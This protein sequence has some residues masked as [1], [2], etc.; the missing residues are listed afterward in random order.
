MIPPLTPHGDGSEIAI[1]AI[2][3]KVERARNFDTVAGPGQNVRNKDRRGND[4]IKVHLFAVM[5]KIMKCKRLSQP[6]VG[7]TRDISAKGAYIYTRMK[8]RKGDQLFLSVH[9]VSDGPPG[10]AP[11]KLEGTGYI[12]R[13]D[14]VHKEL[15][16]AR[17]Y[18]VALQFSHEFAVNF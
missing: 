8:V 16:L 4:R 17:L 12:L 9:I 6:H 18:G 1:P 13:I 3:V 15:P 14:R 7:F 5:R 2:M 10:G 11:P